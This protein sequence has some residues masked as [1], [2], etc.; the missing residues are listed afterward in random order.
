MEILDLVNLSILK[1]EIH[2]GFNLFEYFGRE[3]S[4]ATLGPLLA[5]F[6]EIALPNDCHFTGLALRFDRLGVRHFVY[7]VNEIIETPI[8]SNCEHF[9][10]NF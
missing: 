1:V 9:N 5:N 4:I 7:G 8:F 10:Q 3:S 2:H 6:D